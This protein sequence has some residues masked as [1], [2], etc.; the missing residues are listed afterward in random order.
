MPTNRRQF[1]SYSAA[2]AASASLSYLGYRRLNPQ[3]AVTVRYAGLPLGHLLRDGKLSSPPDKTC[4][5]DTL[6]LGSG[7]AALSAVWY[8]AKQGRRN[9]VLAEG[10]ERNG[11]NAAFVS[12][13]L[14]APS[15]AHYLALPS[16]ES[17]HIR[18][19]LAD[20]GILQPDGRYSDTDLVHAPESRLLYQGKWQEHLLPNND[21]DSR[22]FLALTGR[23]KTA[24]G[25]DGKKIF[26]IPIALSSQDA[27]WRALDRLTF[28]QWLAQEQYR[29]PELLWYL[30]YCCRDDYGQGIAQVSAFAGLHYFASR[31]LNSESVLTW[32]D[33]LAHLSE[34]LRKHSGM[35]DQAVWPSETHWAFARPVA[36]NASAVKIRE[37][38][39]AVEVW[40][41]DNAGGGTVAV[42]AKQVISA[43]PLM[44]VARITE[45]AEHYGLDTLPDYAPWLV[46]N[47]VL[48]RFPA[49][50]AGGE[51]AWDNVLYGSSHL[52]YVVATH[53]QIRAAKPER[54]IFTAYT[55]LNHGK[56]ADTRRQ[57]L[58]ATPQELLA[59]AA[60]D[61][62]AVYGRRFWRAVRNVDI[63]VRGHAMSVPQTGYLSRPGLLKLRAHHSRLVFAH[64]DL[65]G[66]SVFEEASYWGV[67]A[68]KKIL[69]DG[70]AG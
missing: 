5:C 21:A 54:T 3:P 33:G 66:Y 40:L 68:A 2:L 64:S 41:R 36:L 60:E 10:F 39:D 25:S 48:D 63:M 37:E 13:G 16:Q 52:G 62:L 20:F 65:S 1:F 46:S 26:A 11:N 59:L 67:E 34:L 49:E 70:A 44:V 35:Q 14:S 55:A 28:A 9:I 58:A 53:Q 61:L 32:P 7:A 15:G 29:S 17:T 42:R 19:M 47:F 57:L 8:L 4:T 51:L 12:D 69:Q 24:Y 6:I 56:P 30:D 38:A 45:Q 50:P 18:E 22:R 31:G 27:Q 43:M 23:L